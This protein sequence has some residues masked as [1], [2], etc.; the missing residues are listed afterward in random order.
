MRPLA[1]GLIPSMRQITQ[2]LSGFFLLLVFAVSITFSYFNP[3]PIGL[4]IG[5]WQL[6]PQPVSVWVIGAFVLGGL[7]GLLLGLG[8]FR[9]LKSRAE[10]RRLN[11]AL[12]EAE[13][14]VAQL[15]SNSL[16]NIKKQ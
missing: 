10:I 4:D 7:L 6:S 2:L 1:S 14:E 12:R 15:R 5:L 8:I 16:K 9:K 13:I 3:T 11:K